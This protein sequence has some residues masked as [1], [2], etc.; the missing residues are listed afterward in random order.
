MATLLQ[1]FDDLI[2]VLGENLGET[3]G[4]FD[5]IVLSG[6]GETAVDEFLRVVDLG[7]EGQHL[8]S[9]FGDGDGI[10]RQHLDRDTELLGLDDGLGGILTRRVEHGKH[11]EQN[12]GFV[13]LLISDTERA[14][15]TTGE[16]GSLVSEEVGLLLGAAA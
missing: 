9:F 8:A 4:A 5:E 11:A 13:I 12:P 14:E 2:L 16:F 10:T 15:T 1:H 3:I 7:S 6:A